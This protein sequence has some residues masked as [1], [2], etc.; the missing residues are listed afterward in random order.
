MSGFW[1]AVEELRMWLAT[2]IVFCIVTI[3][4]TIWIESDVL[5]VTLVH[6][7][8]GAFVAARFVY[9]HSKPSYLSN[10]H[11]HVMGGSAPSVHEFY[12]IICIAM[13]LFVWWLLNVPMIPTS[14]IAACMIGA[15]WML[16]SHGEGK[17]DRVVAF[18]SLW[19]MLRATESLPLWTTGF[20]FLGWGF[21]RL[22]CYLE[23]GEYDPALVAS[24]LPAKID[25]D[26]GHGDYGGATASTPPL[27]GAPPTI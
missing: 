16:L 12:P 24:D 18:L 19:I 14:M 17:V 7:V 23:A 6:T 26:L 9:R 2:C 25:K 5:I 22:V 13:S 10:F 11:P 15:G 20:L 27:V 8:A 4:A 3:V 1:K 21:L